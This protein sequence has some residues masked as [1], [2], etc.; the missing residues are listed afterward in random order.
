[1]ASKYVEVEV[2]VEIEEFDT[3]ELLEEI[4]KRYNKKGGTGKAERE[5]IDAYISKMKIEYKG[6]PDLNVNKLSLLDKMKIDFVLNHLNQ[7][8]L[9]DLER[10]I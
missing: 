10:L 5:I 8:K 9:D 7:I 3:D 6:F 2:D 4:E 1:M